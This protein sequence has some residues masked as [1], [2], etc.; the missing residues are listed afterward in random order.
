[1]VYKGI[2][3]VPA[4]QVVHIPP[5]A[6]TSEFCLSPVS[7][8]TAQGWAGGKSSKRLWTLFRNS[9]DCGLPKK[10]RGVPPPPYRVVAALR[11]PQG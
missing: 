10:G 3:L 1:M 7:T 4:A 6:T 2:I 8:S 9:F 5:C 11:T